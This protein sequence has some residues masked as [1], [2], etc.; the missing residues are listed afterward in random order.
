MH[1]SNLASLVSSA[2]QIEY[3]A[4][5]MLGPRVLPTEIMS[6]Q[7]SVPGFIPDTMRASGVD[8]GGPP[9]LSQRDRQDFANNLDRFLTKHAKT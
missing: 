3:V 9:A 8:T 6:R 2:D 1:D 5:P 4:D 7:A